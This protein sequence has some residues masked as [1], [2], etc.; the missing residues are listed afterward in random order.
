MILRVKSS[1]AFQ[2]EIA[3]I[4]NLAPAGALQVWHIRGTLI[5]TQIFVDVGQSNIVQKWEELLPEEVET[6][7][8]CVLGT[9]IVTRVGI[10]CSS[11]SLAG[12]LQ[13]RCDSWFIGTSQVGWFPP[14]RSLNITKQP[15]NDMW[16]CSWMFMVDF[17]QILLEHVDYGPERMLALWDP[18]VETTSVLRVSAGQASIVRGTHTHG[19]AML[20]QQVLYQLRRA[21]TI[22]EWIPMMEQE[23]P[24]WSSLSFQH[25]ETWLTINQI[26]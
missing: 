21:I 12:S 24:H 22:Q 9:K 1:R 19:I 3:E 25:G 2:L 15:E 5:P 18:E 11:W 17:G 10:Y 16:R 6:C 23:N 20:P 8:A 26:R 13:L 4:C 14:I 7:K